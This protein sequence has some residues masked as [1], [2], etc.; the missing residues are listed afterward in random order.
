ME[1]FANFPTLVYLARPLVF[2][3]GG[4]VW[5]QSIERCPTRISEKFDDVYIHLETVTAL[6]G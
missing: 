1:I 4:W 3:N 5:S 2:R 6:V